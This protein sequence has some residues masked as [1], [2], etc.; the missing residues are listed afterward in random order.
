M[1]G[2]KWKSNSCEFTGLERPPPARGPTRRESCPRMTKKLST[3]PSH[4]EAHLHD[5]G[6]DHR[7]HAAFE[8]VEKR[9]ADD[10]DDGGDLAGA[11]HD[12]D[13]QRDGED[14]HTFGERARHQED[15]GRQ[16]ADALAEAPPHQFVGGEHLAAEIMRQQQYGDHDAGE[17]V[18]EDHLEEAQVAGEGEGGGADDGQGA[19][20]GGDDG[21]AD[22]PPGGRAAAQEVVAQSRWP[23]RNRA[24]NQVM[25]TR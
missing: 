4:V 12:G 20:F 8:G 10:Q 25:P 23:W 14:P 5:V 9:Q 17:Q 3:A 22:G 13:H 6:P 19:G 2:A 16:L 1:V 24:P 11:E 15:G 18:A 7:R 21:E